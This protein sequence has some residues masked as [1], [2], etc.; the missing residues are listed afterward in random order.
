MKYYMQ[1]P[2][3]ETDERKRYAM[4]DPDELMSLYRAAR[5]R[6]YYPNSRQC[7]TDEQIT[8]ALIALAG[9]Y[10]DL[11][12]YELGQECCVQKLRDIWRARRIAEGEK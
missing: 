6:R 2:H 10:L 5:D 11:T 3:D 12:T 8:D 4:P 1:L 9:G 7:Y